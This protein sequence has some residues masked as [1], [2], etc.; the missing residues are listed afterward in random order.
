MC[1]S[2]TF[3]R[4][5]NNEFSGL[6]DDHEQ[7]V[8]EVGPWSYEGID[9]LVNKRLHWGDGVTPMGNVG[10]GIQTAG[11][12]K[13]RLLFDQESPAGLVETARPHIAHFS[14]SFPIDDQLL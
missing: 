13:V 10:R 2:V 5:D 6:M 3:D 7:F 8:G 9:P 12:A 11:M 14:R 1:T 4:I